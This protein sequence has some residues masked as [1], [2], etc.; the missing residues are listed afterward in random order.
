MLQNLLQQVERFE[1]Y[2]G[3]PYPQAVS[4]LTELISS[5]EVAALGGGALIA[6]ATGLAVNYWQNREANIFP[7]LYSG[8][9]QIGRS[10]QNTAI[11]FY[12]SLNDMVMTITQT[13]NAAREQGRYKIFSERLRNSDILSLARNVES[14][15]DRLLSD[16]KAHQKLASLAGEVANALDNSWEYN[17]H[18]NYIQIPVTTTDSKGNS[19][20]TWTSV[21]VNTDHHFIFHR[22]QAAVA[23]E[24]LTALLGHFPAQNLYQTGFDQLKIKPD[25]HHIDLF[26]RTILENPEGEVTEDE[27]A[28]VVN[29][30]VTKAYAAIVT[31]SVAETLSELIKT[32]PRALEIIQ[33]SEN[34]YEY[35]TSS[36]THQG[37]KS[38]KKSK[39]LLGKC[40]EIR[41]GI[42]GLTDSITVAVA[43]AQDL[44]KIVEGVYNPTFV[45]HR[46]TAQK[47][48]DRA[49]QS[50]LSSFPDSEIDMDQRVK[51]G[52]TLGFA[53][54]AGLVVGLALYYFHPNQTTF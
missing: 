8:A 11:R 45:K 34:S 25:T 10:E 23:T 39:F 43:S 19:N 24:K 20:T 46:R 48:L 18:D 5:P 54:V 47:V 16:L 53:I 41:D 42:A 13:W 3:E 26:K 38:Y 7:V 51:H 35:T 49:V 32:A 9:D 2:D 29:Q 40:A 12:S 4:K 1:R 52:A 15:G 44:Q 27:A 28:T 50:Y 31:A 37:P 6:I 21:Y 33:A 30:W 14:E 36:T 22:E 17:S